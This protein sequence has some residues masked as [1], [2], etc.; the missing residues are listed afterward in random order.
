MDGL[1]Y[2]TSLN[3][4]RKRG[5][6]I[7]RPQS[8]PILKMNLGIDFEVAHLCA[9]AIS[10]PAWVSKLSS[11]RISLTQSDGIWDPL[12]NWKNWTLSKTPPTLWLH[13]Q[14]THRTGQKKLHKDLSCHA[15]HS[16]IQVE[17]WSHWKVWLSKRIPVT[18]TEVEH[19]LRR[20]TYS[21]QN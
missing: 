7:T 10:Y 5:N 14:Y 15:M 11:R 6:A 20:S 17:T 3:S 2:S 12:T 19:H 16:R 21:L 4:K 18:P 1:S 9:N 13:H 8:H